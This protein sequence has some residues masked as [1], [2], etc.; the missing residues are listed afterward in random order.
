MVKI[1]DVYFHEKIVGQLEQDKHGDL[2]FTY[3]ASWL[4]DPAATKISHSLPLQRG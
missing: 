1:L 2:A 3:T 4:R